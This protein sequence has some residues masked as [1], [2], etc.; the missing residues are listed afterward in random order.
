MIFMKLNKYKSKIQMQIV[1]STQVQ[2]AKVP[3]AALL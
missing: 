3:A 2:M 1:C